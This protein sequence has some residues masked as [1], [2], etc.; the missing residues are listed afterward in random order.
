MS[1]I[2][3][4]VQ[5][6]S[7]KPQ[8]TIKEGKRWNFETYVSLHK[9]QHQILQQLEDDHG[10]KGVDEGTKVRYLLAGIKTDKLNTIK[11]Q[12]L[13]DPT[14]QRDFDHC[15]N[16]FKAFLEQVSND[17]TQTFNVSRVDTQDGK[18][19]GRG[20]FKSKKWV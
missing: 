16:L 2:W 19:K 15:V 3:Q 6:P 20:P 11:G 4:V 13:G 1:I 8:S 5:R 14:L 18:P 10:Y 17:R 9:E 7:Y 12:I